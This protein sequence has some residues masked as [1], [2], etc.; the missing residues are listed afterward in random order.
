V[1]FELGLAGGGPAEALLEVVDLLL[2]LDDLV[3]LLVEEVGVVELPG[4]AL[5]VLQREVDAPLEQPATVVMPQP[6]G[7]ANPALNKPKA[8]EIAAS[9]TPRKRRALTQR[10]APQEK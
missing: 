6:A 5:G 9:R 2:E 7:S 10:N 1:V 4:A 3:L 8:E